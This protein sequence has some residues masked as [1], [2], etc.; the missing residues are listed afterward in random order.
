MAF[1]SSFPRATETEWRAAVDRVLKGADFEKTLVGRRRMASRS[2]RCTSGAWWLPAEAGVRG[3]NRWHIVARLEDP[4][5]ERGNAL[6]HEDLIGGADSI[7]LA[8]AGAPAARGFGLRDASPGTLDAALTGRACRS[9]RDP[10]R[11]RAVRRACGGGGALPPM[12]SVTVCRVR[13]SMSFPPPAA[14][15]SCRHRP[16]AAW[17]CRRYEQHP[18]TIRHLQAEGFKG[19]YLRCDGRPFHEAGASE[20]QELASGSSPRPRPTCAALVERGLALAEAPRCSRS[21]SW[22]MTTSS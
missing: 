3:A 13:R 14:L 2:C 15:R 18:D 5:A 19:P 21:R 8:F 12:P 4:D 22:R 11:N 16:D 7:T 9:H 6:I 10:A 17:F 1:A 20:A